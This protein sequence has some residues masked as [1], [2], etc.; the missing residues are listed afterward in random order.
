MQGSGRIK[1]D[2]ED[3]DGDVIDIDSDS[4]L[5]GIQYSMC[6]PSAD[7]QLM[8]TSIHI[9]KGDDPHSDLRLGLNFLCGAAFRSPQPSRV[10]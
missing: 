7:T 2:D 4:G 1:V 6:V 3:G 10:R 5:L 9:R 8:A